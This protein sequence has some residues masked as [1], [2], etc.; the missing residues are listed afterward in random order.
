MKMK[1]EIFLILIS[2]MIK[3]F[4]F[5]DKLTIKNIRKYRYNRKKININDNLHNYILNFNFKNFN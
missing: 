5:K 2:Q 4:E 1:L 3:K